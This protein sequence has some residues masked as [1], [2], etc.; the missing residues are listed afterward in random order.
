MSL[1]PPMGPFEVENTLN[2]GKAEKE[3]EEGFDW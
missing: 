1:K 3:I 2:C